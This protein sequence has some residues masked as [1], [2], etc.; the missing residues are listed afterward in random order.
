MRN[1]YTFHIS[2]YDPTVR[3][4][5]RYTYDVFTT[6]KGAAESKMRKRLNWL[7]ELRIEASFQNRVTT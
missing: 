7:R 2:G 5:V 3:R 1:H 6:S 4:T